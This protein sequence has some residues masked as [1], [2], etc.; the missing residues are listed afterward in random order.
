MGEIAVANIM[1]ALLVPKPTGHETG[2]GEATTGEGKGGSPKELMDKIDL[3]GL[4]EWGQNKQ[5]E[6]WE[7]ITIC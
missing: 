1:P 6:D 4:G 5:K 3:T 2:T 7:L